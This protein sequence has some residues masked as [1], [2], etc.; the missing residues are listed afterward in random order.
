[1]PAVP[2]PH[3]YL[4]HR[5]IPKPSCGARRPAVGPT[6]SARPSRRTTWTPTIRPWATSTPGRSPFWSRAAADWWR[7]P[8]LCRPLPQRGRRARRLLAGHAAPVPAGGRAPSPLPELGPPR[9]PL[10]AIGPDFPARKDMPIGRCA[11]D[12]PR[13]PGD[14]DGRLR[15]RSAL[16]QA[17]GLQEYISNYRRRMFS[18][19]AAV[20]WMY[21][22]SWPVTHGWTIVDY[23]LP[24]EAG[25]PPGAPGLPAGDRGRRRSE[26]RRH[27][28]R[29]Q[30][31]CR[32][33]GRGNCDGAVFMTGRRDCPLT[34]ASRRELSA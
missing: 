22:D 26:R 32:R 17:E 1:M 28:L 4:F 18:S 16:L 11:V 7:L 31:H 20:F 23:Y 21:N 5:D 33:P 29:R 14:G 6:G 12:R 27:R 9:Q 30:R 34:I 10:L 19:A 24:Q 13:S 25:L 2:H 8:H 15:L 3:Y